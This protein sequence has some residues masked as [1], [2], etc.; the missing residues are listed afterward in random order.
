MFWRQDRLDTSA[1]FLLLLAPACS[2]CAGLGLFKTLLALGL[3][4]RYAP[5]GALPGALHHL[6]H[7]W[8]FWPVVMLAVTE[9]VVDM[10]PGGDVRWDRWNGKLRVLGGAALGWMATLHTGIFNAAIMALI[11]AFLA[12]IT[13]GFRSGARLAAAEAGTNKFVSPVTGLT[14]TCM[15]FAILLPL[16]AQPVITFMM[17]CFTLLGGC[18]VMYLVW[19]K[20]RQAWTEVFNLPSAPVSQH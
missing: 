3:L 7:T 10:I 14:E 12:L 1:V 4:H 17:L 9:T 19:P 16:S 11:G 2:W 13:H 18:L 6:G 15:V 8:V 20:V 5:G